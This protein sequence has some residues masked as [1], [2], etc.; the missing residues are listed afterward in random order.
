MY[1]YFTKIPENVNKTL[2]MDSYPLG[3]FCTTTSFS[4]IVK[5]LSP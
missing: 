1:M 2:A 5:E 4:Q 3:F